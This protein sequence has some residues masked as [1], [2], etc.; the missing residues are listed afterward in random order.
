MILLVHENLADLF[1]HRV[2]SQL[3]ALANAVAIIADRII[4]VLQIETE[5]LTRIFRSLHGLRIYG[6][7]CAQII[8]LPG[9]DQR[10]LQLLLRVIG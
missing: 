10:V 4:L 8:D 9:N 2:L 6:G 1:G 3:F 7:H 5:Q